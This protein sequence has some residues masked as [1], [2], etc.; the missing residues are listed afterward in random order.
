MRKSNAALGL[1]SAVRMAVTS[2]RLLSGAVASVPSGRCLSKLHDYNSTQIP[3]I[4]PVQRIVEVAR[5]S[6]APGVKGALNAVMTGMSAFLT[7]PP[8]VEEVGN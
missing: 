4:S 7:L 3:C 1:V 8:P 6:A 5:L 2:K